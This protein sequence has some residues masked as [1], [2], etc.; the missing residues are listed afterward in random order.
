[1]RSGVLK[2]YKINR[3]ESAF[4]EN[5]SIKVLL[6]YVIFPCLAKFSVSYKSFGMKYVDH[7]TADCD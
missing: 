4:A 3:T 5:D 7:E 1:M 2:P 6:R